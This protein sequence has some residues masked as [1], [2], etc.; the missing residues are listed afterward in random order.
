MSKKLIPVADAEAVGLGVGRRTLGR[1]IVNPP[2]GFPRAI[3]INGR[4]FFDS[5]ELDA[6][7]LALISGAASSQRR[8][9]A[10]FDEESGR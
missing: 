7:K 5:E 6:Y 4:L 2:P 1:R 3:R 10:L 8:T 9:V